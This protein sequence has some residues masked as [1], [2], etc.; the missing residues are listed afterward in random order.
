MGWKRYLKLKSDAC[1]E[2]KALIM[3]LKTAT[4]RKVKV[5]RFNGGGEFING[6]LLEWLKKRGTTIEISAPNTKQQN[7][8][9]KQFNQTT[10]E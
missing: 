3:E 6:P 5:I 7:G 1:D 10:H 2:I 4:E 8:V 9:A